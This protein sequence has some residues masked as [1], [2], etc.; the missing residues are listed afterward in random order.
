MTENV[1]MQLCA[2]GKM[3]LG[4]IIMFGG[5]DSERKKNVDPR[6]MA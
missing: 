2:R 6:R 5:I 4:A 3:L 1:R